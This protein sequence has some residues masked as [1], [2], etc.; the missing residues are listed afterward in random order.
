MRLEQV[1]QRERVLAAAELQ[2]DAIMAVEG[3]Q[4]DGRPGA[5]VRHRDPP[6]MACAQLGKALS[7]GMFAENY[8]YLYCR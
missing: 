3:R 5:A 2:D 7:R 1:E 6:R 8:I 4:V